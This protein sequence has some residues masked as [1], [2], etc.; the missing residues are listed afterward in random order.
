M[1][2]TPLVY[3]ESHRPAKHY[4]RNERAGHTLQ[5][6]AL[7]HEAHLPLI[8][9]AHFFAIADRLIRQILMDFARESGYQ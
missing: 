4:M 2:L 9:A 3:A 1:E 6:T 5:T 7:I 8:D